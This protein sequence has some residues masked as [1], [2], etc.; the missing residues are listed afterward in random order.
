MSDG[1]TYM[2]RKYLYVYGGIAYDCETA[3]LDLWRYEIPYGP[4]AMFPKKLN[5][6]H[7]RGNH[8][9]MVIEDPNYSPGP[10]VKASM[11]GM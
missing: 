1:K 8:W 9:R 2:L 7:N 3:C 11:A 4:I 10:R 6:W 5:K